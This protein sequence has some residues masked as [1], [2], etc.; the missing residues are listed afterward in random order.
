M[1]IK[2]NETLSGMEGKDNVNIGENLSSITPNCTDNRCTDCSEDELLQV[3]HPWRRYFARLL[4]MSIYNILWSAFLAFV[5]H[6]NLAS[7]SNIENFLDTF[8][9]IIIML[10]LEPLFLHLFGTTPGKAIFGLKIETPDGRML[11]YSEGLERTW[12]V[13]GIGMG[14]NIPIYTL[15]R[16]WKSYS[17]CSDNETQPWDEFISYTIKDTKWYRS[18]IYIGANAVILAVLITI[19]SA[20]YLPPN[21]GDLTIAEYVENYNYYA[22]FFDI[23]NEY[24]DEDGKWV[25]QNHDGTVYIQIGH[26][27]KPEYNFSFEN[28]Y[29]SGVSFEVEINNN[30]SFLSSYNT[31]MFLASLAFA[32]AQNEMKL[33]SK[34]PN[35][36]AKQIESKSFEDF[37]FKEAGITFTCDTEYSG[38]RYSQSDF[39]FPSENS[40]ENYFS[41]NFLMTK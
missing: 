28:G 13:I 18:I 36:I 37:S 11:S 1:T 33:Y 10:F 41:L 3:F 14:F 39:L 20:Q 22:K 6:L 40:A 34:I 17:L 23:G 26:G 27:K 15:V 29:V 19:I 21:R 5:F 25:K 16:L 30:E 35:R 31:Q 24:L 2:K 8:I 7:R 38:Y 32:G 12:R 9:A 4:D